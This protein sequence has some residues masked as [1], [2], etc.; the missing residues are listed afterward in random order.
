MQQDFDRR[1]A[2]FE[3]DVASLVRIGF[4]T[5]DEAFKDAVE[6]ADFKCDLDEVAIRSIVDC[7]FDSLVEEEGSWPETTDFDRLDAA[8]VNLEERGFVALHNPHWAPSSAS[9]IAEVAHERAGGAPAGK[10]YAVYYHAQS[11]E[12]AVRGKGLDLSFMAFPG[13]PT[14]MNEH[15]AWTAA[16]MMVVEALAA[17]G[18]ATEWSGEPTENILVAMN[19]QKRHITMPLPAP[20]EGLLERP[21]FWTPPSEDAI[22]ADATDFARL[23]GLRPD[24]A[25][26]VGV[27]LDL[28]DDSYKNIN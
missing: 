28:Q 2:E 8:F 16:G 23:F 13:N 19:W 18:L 26:L 3:G 17:Q 12:R 1:L 11:V 14:Y 24:I 5:R 20:D 6:L 10:H 7:L 22:R 15:T 21:S 9:Y 27:E 25:R 4:K